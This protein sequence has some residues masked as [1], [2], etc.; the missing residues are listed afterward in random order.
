MSVKAGKNTSLLINDATPS[1]ISSGMQCKDGGSIATYAACYVKYL[2]R[3]LP[4][5]ALKQECHKCYRKQRL[6]N[7]HGLDPALPTNFPANHPLLV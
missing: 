6:I 5:G 3:R 2:I 1:H 4:T 7:I